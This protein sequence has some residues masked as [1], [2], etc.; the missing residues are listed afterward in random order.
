MCAGGAATRGLCM[1]MQHGSLCTEDSLCTVGVLETEVHDARGAEHAA[2][3]DDATV[4]GTRSTTITRV[5]WQL[6]VLQR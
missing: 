2:A 4:R 5:S 1:G 3:D 6:Y